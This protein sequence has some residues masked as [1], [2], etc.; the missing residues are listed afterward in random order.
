MI[1]KYE[2]IR[3]VP[4]Y[5]CNK[6]CNFCYQKTKDCNFADISK[7]ENIIQNIDFIPAYITFMGGELSCFPEESKKLFSTVHSI[8]P[9]VFAKSIITNGNGDLR[10]YEGLKNDGISRIIFSCHN[11]VDFI[12]MREKI[13]TLSKS[14]F[15]TTRVNC[16]L[17]KDHIDQAKK[18]LN[19]C[20]VNDI[21]LTFCYD[22]REQTNDILDVIK[23]LGHFT[24]VELYNNY[25]IVRMGNYSFWV[26]YH[27]DYKQ[28]NLIILPDGSTTDDF[29]DV[30]DCKGVC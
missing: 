4:T 1:Q 10:W 12:A 20:G 21:P 24:S 17:D 11:D 7:I 13:I 5:Y 2:G 29:K 18:I 26:Y 28:N 22:L 30:E 6:H 19:I 23:P 25:C 3:I 15:F 16:F 14:A 9:M 27:K 8:L